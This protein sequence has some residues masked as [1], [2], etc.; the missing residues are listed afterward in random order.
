MAN[1]YNR[2][3]VSTSTTGTG[4]L[5]LGAAIAGYFTFDE[6]GVQDADVVPY[7][8]ED[9]NDFEIGTGTYTASGTTLTRTV[10]ESKIGGVAGT[11][12]INLS[13]N[14]TVFI[15]A[16]AEDI[17]DVVGP[18][19]ATD[20]AIAR[21]HE[22]T[23]KIIQNSGV[24]IDDSDNVSGIV[25]LT[26]TGYTDL[27][28]ISTPSNPATNS[29]RE[30]ARDDGGLSK[31]YFV[32]SAGNEVTPYSTGQVA[33]LS[34]LKAL[35][36]NL[37]E[38]VVMQ[39]YTSAG[40][41]GGG[42]FRWDGSDLSTEVAADTRSGVYVPPNSDSDGS[43]GA[44][45]RL[46]PDDVIRA[47]YFGAV[48]DSDASGDGSS[49]SSTD[50]AAAIQAA[51]DYGVSLAR[52]FTIEL[53]AK[54]Y[55]VASELDFTNATNG[56][57]LRGHGQG[58]E[59]S[60]CPTPFGA[61]EVLLNLPGDVFYQ[62]SDFRIRRSVDSA[63]H[64]I[65]IYA[66]D[67]SR[68]KLRNLAFGGLGNTALWMS[69]AFNCDL[70]D[71][72]IFS[73]GWQW[74]ERD[75]PA[76]TTV[77]TTSGSAVVTANEAVW[78]AGDVGKT[79][80]IQQGDNGASPASESNSVLAASIVSVD[81]TTQ[82]TIDED[83]F[84]SD[85]GRRV[86]FGAVT[87]SITSSDATLA[88]NSDVLG[89]GDVGRFIYVEGAGPNGRTLVAK[90]ASVTD[91]GECELDTNAST[92][93]NNLRVFTAPA[94]VMT[95]YDATQ[96]VNDIRF[97]RV[98][99]EQWKSVGCLSDLGT[100]VF[101]TNQKFH[102]LN[103]QTSNFA[104]SAEAMIIGS[105]TRCVIDSVE[106]EFGCP[107]LGSGNF[108]IY[109][110]S[111]SVEIDHITKAGP[112]YGDT[113]LVDFNATDTTYG[114]LIIGSVLSRIDW[115]LMSGAVRKRSSTLIRRIFM[116]GPIAGGEGINS[117]NEARLPFTAASFRSMPQHFISDDG[118]ASIPLV[119]GFGYIFLAAQDT[120]NIIGR[121]Y[122]RTTSSPSTIAESVG[123]LVDV[124][125]GALTGTTGTDGRVTVSAAD[126][127]IYIENRSGAGRTFMIVILA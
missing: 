120:S 4:T 50:D 66:P 62:L 64:P 19:S 74:L 80:Y 106:V 49:D 33:T 12:A 46:I 112:C 51:I 27:A 16:R 55:K 42:L 22:T 75:I 1:L 60:L 91:A 40:D 77:T 38:V 15:T 9:G 36:A 24:T 83:A 103:Y 5:T 92:T 95:G 63:D 52:A 102:G 34:A 99:I 57:W 107:A 116:R 47:E 118:V 78:D 87:G 123:S 73:S 124:T 113:Y 44:W 58:G 41:G 125:T 30:F 13:G 45:V 101:M 11:S 93:V 117:E 122:F 69:R 31:K 104:R 25:N 20:N 114:T 79:I 105:T 2:A 126:G 14:A 109:G 18:A 70:E 28:E 3:R 6:A 68:A 90:I 71:L 85:S 97:D 81:S 65:A 26:Q 23:G 67:M 127:R 82:I 54:N 7:T 115:R 121:I 84:V 89:A 48:G 59:S 29:L 32:D 10:T 111:P 110:S 100:H 88:L 53:A 37:Y 35:A 76:S 94:V 119:N 39:G 43:S 56:F 21:Y 72:D 96:G 86:S 17:G 61:A 98:L 108:K 8:I